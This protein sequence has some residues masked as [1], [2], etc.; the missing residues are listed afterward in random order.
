MVSPL[1]LR[2]GQSAKTYCTRE[3]AW[4]VCL[5]IF[6]VSIV[7]N[8]PYFMA[9]VVDDGIQETPFYRGQ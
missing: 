6:P 3:M 5:V 1:L 8:I 9:F 2:N 4:R 7:F